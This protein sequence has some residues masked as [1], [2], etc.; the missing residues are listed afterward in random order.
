MENE[1]SMLGDSLVGTFLISTSQMPD[2]RFESHVIYICAHT[3]DGA[4]GVAI[5]QPNTDIS[6]AEILNGAQLPIPCGDLPQVYIGGPV[7]LESAFI[8]YENS[9]DT[10]NR[11]DISDTVSLTRETKV[12]QDIALGRGPENFLFILGYSGWGLVSLRGS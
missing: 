10:E 3:A 2:P 11:L 4:M 8:L 6:F 1:S 9:Y 5:N 7:E 12:L